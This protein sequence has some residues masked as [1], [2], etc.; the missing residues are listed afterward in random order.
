M[1]H[2]FIYNG[3]NLNSLGFV[4]KNNP[5]YKPPERNREFFDN[6]GGNGSEI[7]DLGGFKNVEFPIEIN[8]IPYWNRQLSA[9]EK[10]YAL[11][12]WLFADGGYHQYRDTYNMGYFTEAVFVNPDEISC[13]MEGVLD[14][15]LTVSRRPYWYSD[16]GAKK[17]SF[18]S[19]TTTL[20]FKMNN[21]EHYESEPYFKIFTDGSFRLTVGETILTF[22][23]CDSYVEI[24][25]EIDN[26][27]KGSDDKNST[28]SGDY[29][30]L[31]KSGETSCTVQS[32]SGNVISKV[33]VIPRWRRI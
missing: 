4:I 32:L 25:T 16:L 24:D 23:E 8:S 18:E 14:T 2:D 7:S 31:L 26:V 1:I 22:S 10:A 33:E 15:T 6:S 11:Y 30:P 9:R 13:L 5:H 3:K 21:P 20:S 19:E 17:A 12:D 27:F 28:F 29:M